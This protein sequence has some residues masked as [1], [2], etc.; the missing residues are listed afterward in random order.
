MHCI[1]YYVKWI[2][3]SYKKYKISASTRSPSAST[4]SVY[5]TRLSSEVS[6]NSLMLIFDLH[7]VYS[8]RGE[9]H[10]II[11]KQNIYIKIL[12]ISAKKH[13]YGANWLIHIFKLVHDLYM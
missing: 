9:S 5:S 8:I 4:P 7:F 1:G 6:L 11:A 13:L 10:A 12:H 2:K 3:F